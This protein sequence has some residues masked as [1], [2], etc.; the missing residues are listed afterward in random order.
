MP[1]AGKRPRER[2][3]TKSGIK[4]AGDGVEREA[5][6]IHVIIMDAFQDAKHS[7]VIKAKLHLLSLFRAGA[8]LWL[9][10]RRLLRCG[11]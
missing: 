5:D 6:A 8:S 7:G 2:T 10:Y 9:C 3:W 1:S 4:G 11:G